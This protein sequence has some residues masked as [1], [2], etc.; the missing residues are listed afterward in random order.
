MCFGD[1]A[2]QQ[3]Q[4]PDAQQEE[5]AEIAP[6]MQA[7]SCRRAQP[8][9]EHGPPAE[10][11]PTSQAPSRR[12]VPS[13]ARCRFKTSQRS[14]RCA[15]R[16]PGFKEA[17]TKTLLESIEEV[18]PIGCDECEYVLTLQKK[19][20]SNMNR[21]VDTPCRKFR[22]LYSKKVPSGNP[23]ISPSVR[24]AKE[25]K[26][27]IVETSQTVGGDFLEELGFDADDES[28][29]MQ[30]SP[31]ECAGGG[32]LAERK[33]S[34]MSVEDDK[35]GDRVPRAK[36]NVIQITSRRCSRRVTEGTLSTGLNRLVQQKLVK[37]K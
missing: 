3:S 6:T 5:T 28:R 14:V 21:T 13:V 31:T 33:E 16:G 34:Q 15:A 26:E 37:D 4:S 32:S 2:T 29:P 25:F 12:R 18:T 35:D 24:K 10:S 20:W 17:E 22:L 23:Y 30:L 11:E 36:P 27:K 7:P 9:A 1:S 8:V 19:K